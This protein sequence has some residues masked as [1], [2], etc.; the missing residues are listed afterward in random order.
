MHARCDKSR[1]ILCSANP[2][3]N[4]KPFCNIST[5][6]TSYSFFLLRR[7]SCTCQSFIFLS[8]H[9][10]AESGEGTALELLSH[11]Q[12]HCWGKPSGKG[13]LPM[14]GESQR[15]FSGGWTMRYLRFGSPRITYYSSVHSIL[16]NSSPEITWVCVRTQG[17]NDVY[18][19]SSRKVVFRTI[20]G[21]FQKLEL[22]SQSFNS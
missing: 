16:P 6:S 19:W 11:F 4:L 3:I 13:L 2:T 8:S 21:L 7:V 12:S 10:W 18:K 15:T 9:L 17:P 1:T 20:I 5:W 22:P 14:A